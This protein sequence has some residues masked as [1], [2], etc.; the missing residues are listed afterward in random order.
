[1]NATTGDMLYTDGMNIA[2]GWGFRQDGQA[3][4]DNW[5][6]LRMPIAEQVLWG[7]LFLSGTGF[8]QDRTEVIPDI[9][10]GDMS[11]FMF[12]LGGGIR[13]TIP[14]L[15]IGLYF[16]KRFE[17]IDGDLTWIA[18]DIFR[19]EDRPDSGVDLVIAFQFGLF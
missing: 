9:R 4:W 5:I 18:G 6:E 16:T 11:N 14:G 7:D 2:R 19:D 12:S 15:P 13:F 3:M 1:M 10:S 8:W 17:F